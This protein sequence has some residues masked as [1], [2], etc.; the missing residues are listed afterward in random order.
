MHPPSDWS[1]RAAL[2]RLRAAKH[3]G[4]QTNGRAD[5]TL[6]DGHHTMKMEIQRCCDNRQPFFGN[7]GA[8]CA[9]VQR[10][11]AR[12]PSWHEATKALDTCTNAIL[13]NELAACMTL[14]TAPQLPSSYTFFNHQIIHL[15]PFFSFQM[16]NFPILCFQNICFLVNFNCLFN[17]K[18]LKA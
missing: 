17:L 11:L 9:T 12:S 10:L 1:W 4:S 13:C 16:Y 7:R 18:L 14:T 5:R 15:P 6:T 2:A 8:V 3:R